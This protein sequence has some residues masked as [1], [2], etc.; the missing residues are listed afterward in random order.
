MANSDKNILITPNKSASGIPEISLTGFGASTVSIAI[1][2]ST[3]G[4]LNFVSSGSSIFSLDTNI[5]T[6]KL[7]DVSTSNN[8]PIL[9]ITDTTSNIGAELGS[10]IVEGDG[11]IIPSVGTTALPSLSVEGTIT[12]D[13]NHQ[14]LKVFNG[15]IWVPVGCQKSGLTA[16]TAAESSEQLIADYPDSPT[17]FYWILVDS[18][19]HLFWVDMVYQGGGW[20]LV[21]SNRI[22][23]NGMT[24]LNYASATTRVINYRGNY[25]SATGN[26]PT[27]FNL[28]VGLDAW[29]KLANANFSTSNRVCEFVA[30]SYQPLGAVHNHTKRASWN[31]TG[32]GGSYAWQGLSDAYIELG[33]SM[34]GLY[35]YHAA[36][37][38]NLTT[39]DVDQDANGGNCSTFYNNTPNWYGSCW[40][41][42]PFGGGG[43]GGYADA[44]FW[45]GSGGDYHNY[46]ALYVR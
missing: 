36:S 10:V 3:T 7:F 19:P 43:G 1:D 8:V 41:G 31:W 37:G 21:I 38:F 22:N 9:E 16:D 6:G 44:W 29:V 39:F 4:K 13:D 20:I 2:D 15:S 27:N 17:G 11:L 30:G 32:W 35:S 23:T 33:G 5:N 45:D 34:P 14:T 42:N 28:W 26:N 25:Y 40:S 18:V 46:G 12:Y 24:G